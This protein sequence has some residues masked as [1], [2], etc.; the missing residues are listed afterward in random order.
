MMVGTPSSHRSQTRCAL[1]RWLRSQ[2]ARA[3]LAAAAAA[4]MQQPAAP[5]PSTAAPAG[6]RVLDV[7]VALTLLLR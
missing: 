7:A 5:R 6:C 3:A 4:A 1:L 2:W